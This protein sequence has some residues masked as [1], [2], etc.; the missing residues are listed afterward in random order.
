MSGQ[1]KAVL[2]NRWRDALR[3]TL[4]VAMGYLA[5]GV[6]YGVLAGSSGLPA[7]FA[8]G[9]SFLVFSGTA[10]YAAIP[11]FVAGTGV[12]SV[13]LSTLMMSLRFVFYTLNMRDD[14]PRQ[15]PVQRFFAVAYLV[16]ESFALLNTLPVPLRRALLCKVNVLGVLYWTLATVLGF[17]LGGSL[18]QYIPHLDFAL[19]CWFAVLAYEQYRN[20]REWLPLGLAV[21]G[22]VVA[23][24]V[25]AEHVFLLAVLVAVLL[26]AVLPQQWFGA[27][28]QVHG[29]HGDA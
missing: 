28:A 18:G 21:A 29:E 15:S 22:F 11:F 6:A 14:L 24:L 17:A 7:W 9:M 13:F 23:R 12:L 27:S 8:V 4:P 26:I 19:P 10:Q 2:Q 20:R 25:S 1:T 3:L 16:D 5:A